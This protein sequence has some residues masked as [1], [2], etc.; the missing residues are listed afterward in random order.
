MESI[1]TVVE[2]ESNKSSQNRCG[3]RIKKRSL[4]LESPFTNSEKIRK[5][6]NVNTFNPFRELDP[7]KVNDLE[8]WLVNV[9]DRGDCGIYAIKFI[10]LLSAELEVKLM[11]DAM[12]ESWRKN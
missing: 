6:H 12:I 9:P 1:P 4:I 5:L 8:N 10:E 11:S 7:D 3:M 2:D